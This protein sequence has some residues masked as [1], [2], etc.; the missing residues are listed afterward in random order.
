MAWRADLIKHLPVRAY[1]GDADNVVSARNSIEMV[2]AVNAAGGNAELILFHN[3][4]H[5]SWINAYEDSN[6]V[7]WLYKHT[8][9]KQ[10]G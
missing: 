4:G 10:N 3:V 5:P 7:Q 1:H 6:L 8:K 9:E 2:D